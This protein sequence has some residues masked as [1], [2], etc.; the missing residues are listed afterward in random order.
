MNNSKEDEILLMEV[1]DEGTLEE[2]D[3]SI[4]DSFEV[5]C[6]K[7]EKQFK[8]EERGSTTGLYFCNTCEKELYKIKYFYQL[9]LKNVLEEHID[10]ILKIYPEHRKYNLI[11]IQNNKDILDVFEIFLEG[12]KPL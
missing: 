10:R 8:D 9:S 6:K 11:S 1:D 2:Y 3:R 5:T 12:E 4:D 7:C